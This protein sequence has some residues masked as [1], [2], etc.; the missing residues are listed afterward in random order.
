MRDRNGALPRLLAV[1]CLL[2]L[3]VGVVVSLRVGAPPTL[4]LEAGLPAIGARTPVK[5]VAEEPRRGLAGLRL[6][7]IQ[8][9]RVLVLAEKSYAA[10]P[11]WKLWGPL[12]AREELRVEVGRETVKDLRGGTV[13]LRAT[14]ARAGTWLRS[15]QPTLREITL[16]VRLDPPALELA[17]T[18]HYVA[19]GGAEV[20]VYRVGESSVRDGVRAGERFFPGFPLPGGGARDRFALF[21]VPY[22]Q[23]DAGHVALEATDDVGN[24]ARRSFVDRF[25]ARPPRKD[26]IQ[27]TQ[28]FLEKVVPEIRGQTPGLAD[29][30]GLLENYL[31]INGDLRR[32]NAQ[33]LVDLAR[34]SQPR[35][36]WSGAFLPLRSGKV[37]SSFADRRTYVLDGREVDH[38]DHLGFDLASVQS[39]PVPASNEGLVVLARYFGIY[40]NTV[41]VDH[42]YGLMTLYAHLS[43]IDVK[44]GQAVERGQVLGRTGATGLAGGDHLHF[45][46]LLNGL[47]TTP[48]E[49]W[50]GHWIDDRLRRKLGAAL[51]PA[52]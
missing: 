46:V 5:V 50:D 10:R 12:T 18:Q 44:D 14:A 51:P 20:V 15:A 25:F 22:D 38:Q 42:G 3:V 35:F 33:E 32:S 1:L 49:W 48:A 40:G 37:M 19:Q 30:G 34:R 9:E 11:A 41:I 13:T 28:K 8:G 6:E 39:A 45:T 52:E 7:L 21:A 29:K 16:P 43:A 31:A 47:P 2:L 26:T 36:L 27:L 17:S 23:P 4:T 24:T